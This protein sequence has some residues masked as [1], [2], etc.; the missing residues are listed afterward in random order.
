MSLADECRNLS[1]DISSRST[2]GVRFLSAGLSGSRRSA[3]AISVAIAAGLILCA[4]WS[5][6]PNMKVAGATNSRASIAIDYPLNNSVFPPD[7]E[8]PT[9]Q[10]RDS[11]EG[12]VRWQIDVTFD[13]GSQSLHVTSNGEGL[14][15]GAIDPRC[16]SAN[17]K[18]PTLTAE[19]ATAH[20]WKPDTATWVA[21]REHAVDHA[22]SVSI[23]GYADANAGEALSR[24]VRQLSVSRDPVGAPIF[25]RDVPLM[26][27]ATE[28]G[29]IKPLANL[30]EQK[31]NNRPIFCAL[32]V[33]SRIT[34]RM[35]P[36]GKD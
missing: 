2:A 17:N 14:K 6:W 21:I 5:S 26:P 31:M 16:I 8:A 7:M 12:G 20:T 18:L 10:W 3:R 28:K 15:I 32:Q 4:A 29:V 36:C 27:S 11:A 30:L 1:P 9:F 35:S 33:L 23:S 25:Y 34:P 19:Q 22:A 24:E 13:D